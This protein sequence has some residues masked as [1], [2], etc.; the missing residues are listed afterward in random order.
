MPIQKEK[1]GNS[2]PSC[3]LGHSKNKP[4]ISIEQYVDHCQTLRLHR[5]SH[6]SSETERGRHI[7]R[8]K[9]YVLAYMSVLI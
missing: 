3:E 2:P 7:Q 1:K 8:C 5:L 9:D 4:E 6:A